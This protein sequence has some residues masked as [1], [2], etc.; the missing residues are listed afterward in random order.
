MGRVDGGRSAGSPYFLGRTSA[1]S[2]V[3]KVF[4]L[5]GDRF[6]FYSNEGNPREA[7]HVH[8]RNADGEAKFWISPSVRLAGNS[9]MSARQLSE[10]E[11]VVEQHRD[12]IERA[13]NDHFS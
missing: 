1:G 11:K 2:V 4:E 7:A 8:V 12:M 9:G 5:N 6:F 3:P 13:W 10:I